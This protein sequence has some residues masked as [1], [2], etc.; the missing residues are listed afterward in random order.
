MC[1]ETVKRNIVFFGYF[2]DCHIS[3]YLVGISHVGGCP[4]WRH[5]GARA[6]SRGDFS[7]GVTVGLNNCGFAVVQHL[8]LRLG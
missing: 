6:A 1:E 3:L 4:G 8:G 7:G 5:Y 2:A